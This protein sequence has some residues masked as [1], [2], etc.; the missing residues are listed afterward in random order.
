MDLTEPAAT[1]TQSKSSSVASPL[2]KKRATIDPTRPKST[3]TKSPTKLRIKSPAKKMVF[4]PR[5]MQ[6]DRIG[7]MWGEPYKK[8]SSTHKRLTKAVTLFILE[9]G[10]P[11]YAV[12]RR[13]LQ[14]L[15]KAFDKR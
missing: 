3:K 11:A 10:L 15:L 13:G 5:G 7:A 14:K 8:G 1:S 9:D 6:S 4:S 2:R 12:E